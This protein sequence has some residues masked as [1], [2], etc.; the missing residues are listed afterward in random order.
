MDFMATIMEVLGVERPPEQRDWAFDGVSVLPILRGQTPPTRGIGWI[1]DTADL[2]VQK[3]YGYRYGK[4]KY[5]QGSIS[6]TLQSCRLP[7]LY[8]LSTDLGERHDIS[9]QHPST[10]KAIMANFTTWHQSIMHSIDSESKCAPDFKVLSLYEEAC[11]PGS[12]NG[13]Q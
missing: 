9:A 10:L 11:P 5:V 6:C 3:G 4:W 2:N 7:Q 1:F 8:D 12:P 13:C